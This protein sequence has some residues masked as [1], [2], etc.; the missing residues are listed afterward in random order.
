MLL[1]E[2]HLA[3]FPHRGVVERWPATPRLLQRFAKMCTGAGGRSRSQANFSGAGLDSEL[4]LTPKL[5]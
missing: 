5:E 4:S 2:R 1:W 3:G